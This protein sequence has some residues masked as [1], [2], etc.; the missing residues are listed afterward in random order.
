MC[1]GSSITSFF[2]C[3][4]SRCHI[5]FCIIEKRF[6]LAPPKY[7]C[8]TCNDNDVWGYYCLKKAHIPTTTTTW[9]S[10]AHKMEEGFIQRGAQVGNANRALFSEHRSQDS[11]PAALNTRFK[12]PATSTGVM[13]WTHTASP[14]L[15]WWPH[16]V[17]IAA[18]SI[19]LRNSIANWGVEIRIKDS[20]KSISFCNQNTKH[21]AN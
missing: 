6:V 3:I 8:L 21:T 2:S 5:Y 12:H 13:C 1:S 9:F 15:P 16:K 10:G 18:I 7:L 20:L 19:C 11:V 17:Q 4:A 14:C